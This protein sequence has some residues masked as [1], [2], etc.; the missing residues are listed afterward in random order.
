MT[1]FHSDAPVLIYGATFAGLAM[2][3][4][5][6]KQSILVE[7]SSLVGHEYVNSYRPGHGLANRPTSGIGQELYDELVRRNIVQ[8]DGAVHLPGISPVLFHFIRKHN[9][10]IRM[11]TEITEVR[12]TED[13]YE[14]MLYNTSGSQTVQVRNII[15]TTST[16]GSS[17]LWNPPILAKSINAILDGPPLAASI[18]D[19]GRS[20]EM[21]QGGFPS[22]IYFQLKVDNKDNWI[23]AR[24]KLHQF[25]MNRPKMLRPWKLAAVADTFDIKVNQGVQVAAMGSS[26]LPSCAYDN[27]ME[28][29]EAGISYAKQEVSPNDFIRN[30]K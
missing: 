14:V 16:C 30:S 1:A 15:D 5:L 23:V 24:D 21:V 28:A 9:L 6:G 29:F 2:A 11:M 19:S 8:A 7:R 13:G 22:E 10:N 27:F 18:G 3:Y 20:Y 25:W 17:H 4:S 26:W 12:S